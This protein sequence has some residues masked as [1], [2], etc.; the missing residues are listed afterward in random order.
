MLSINSLWAYSAKP[1]LEGGTWGHGASLLSDT[2]PCLFGNLPVH[3]VGQR[4]V[5]SPEVLEITCLCMFTLLVDF[6]ALPQMS[7]NTGLPA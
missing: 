5:F 6:S 3:V 1:W 2:L 4:F 7:S